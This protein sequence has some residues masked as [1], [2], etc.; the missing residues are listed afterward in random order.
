MKKFIFS[1]RMF[2]KQKLYHSILANLQNPV[3]FKF[4]KNNFKNVP[5]I[6]ENSRSVLSTP[7]ISLDPAIKIESESK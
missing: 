1:F 6:V 4:L 5:K 3:I 2:P 7:G